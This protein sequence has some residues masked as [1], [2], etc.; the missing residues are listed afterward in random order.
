VIIIQA[1]FF[2]I[3]S[4]F[5]QETERTETQTILTN[6]SNMFL[7]MLQYSKQY[8]VSVYFYQSV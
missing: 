8:W 4:T 3:A 7:A 2:S 5:S 1:F 6:P